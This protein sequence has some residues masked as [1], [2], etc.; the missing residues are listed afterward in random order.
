[1]REFV[2]SNNQRKYYVLREQLSAT[3]A[4]WHILLH[5]KVPEMVRKV[6]F[7]CF[8]IQPAFD[9]T[10]HSF[11]KIRYFSE[12]S[13]KKRLAELAKNKKSMLCDNGCVECQTGMRYLQL[14]LFPNS[15]PQMDR[16]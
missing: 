15:M 12:M 14:L 5:R 11:L 3:A 13:K 10:I 6:I 8:E 4:F 16:W 1:M 2:N 9:L 7:W